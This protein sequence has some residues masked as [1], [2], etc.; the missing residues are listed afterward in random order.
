M[1]PAKPE[2]LPQPQVLAA[3]GKTRPARDDKPKPW[4]RSQRDR[5][6][7]DPLSSI[8]SRPPQPANS[9]LAERLRDPSLPLRLLK[10][11]LFAIVALVVGRLLIAQLLRILPSPIDQLIGI[12]VFGVVILIAWRAIDRLR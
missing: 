8:Q 4:E 6:R 3:A 5:S 12:V 9:S 11:I 1:S 7:T 2:P 10:A